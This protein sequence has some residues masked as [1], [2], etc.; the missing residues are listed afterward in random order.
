MDIQTRTDCRLCGHKPLDP[1]FSLGDLYVSNFV[2]NKGDGDRGPLDLV[3]CNEK[4]GGCGLVQLQHTASHEALY[5]DYWYRSGI[6]K[7][8]TD[9]LQGI[10][11]KVESLV[12][13][14]QG[15]YVIDIGANDGTLLRGYTVKG[16]N[17]IGY[18][19]ARNLD[20]YNSVGT[21]KVF[22]DFFNHAV[23]QKTFG[24]AK[25]RAITAIAMFYDL[26]DPNLF[27][28]DIA[29]CLDDDGV[30]IVQMSY[31]PLMLET[32]EVGNICHEHVEYYSLLS[33]ENL[34][35]RNN[36]EVADV[37]LN[38]INGGSFRLYIRHSAKGEKMPAP[39]GASIR[40]AALRE[41]EKKLGLGDKKVYEDF[42]KRVESIKEKTVSF[43]KNE[44][45]TGKTVYVYGAS[46]K[47]NTVLQYFGLDEK[48]IKAA[49]ERNPDKWGKKTV[50]THI[51]IISEDQARKEKPDYFLV[52]PWHFLAEFRF[53]E[54]EFFAQGGK[55]IVP[56]PEVM[57]LDN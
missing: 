47:G 21:T 48:L 34:L 8:M 24:S 46:T 52:L 36:L 30:F 50:G 19:P 10:T 40:V 18:E 16:V 14:K 28:S 20:K 27:V 41:Y 12:K 43:V 25:A 39:I 55:F 17:L 38:D 53:R 35:S 7:T 22:Q 51:P 6:N 56:F 31:L 2:D 44:V 57:I 54:K 49:A 11:K 4:E 23:W 42:V 15:D 13:L 9:E 26:E 1:I 37:E 32:N 29:K 45:A 3:L 33:M 5:R